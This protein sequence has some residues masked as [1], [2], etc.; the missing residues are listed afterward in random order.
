MPALPCNT[1]AAL[2]GCRISGAATGEWG[3]NVAK[4][5]GFAALQ[6]PDSGGPGH[7][8]TGLVTFRELR[9]RAKIVENTSTSRSDPHR[10]TLRQHFPVCRKSS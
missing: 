10:G 6:R 3:T 4:P 5:G 7:A 9:I 1:V 2:S 8:S